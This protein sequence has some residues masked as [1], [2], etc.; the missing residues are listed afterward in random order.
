MPRRLRIAFA[1]PG[2]HRVARGAETAF[3]QIARR[4]ASLGHHVTVFG[5]G[6]PRP[7][8]PYCYRRIPCVPREFFENWPKFPC[9]RTNYAWEELTFSAGLLL[10]YRPGDFDLAIGCSY[11]Y[12]NWILSRGIGDF[13]R[14]VFVTQNGD[15]MIQNRSAEYRFFDCDAVVC[16]NAQ[17]FARHGER[18]PSALIPNGVDPDIFYPGRADRAA[19][20]LP[21]AGPVALMVSA[22]IP[23]KRVVEGV[24]A[25]ANVPGLFLVVAGDGECR[26][27]VDNEAGHLMPGRY[28]RLSLPRER[29]PGL[30]RCADA[31]LH[32]SRDEASANAYMEA[33][34][35]GLPIVTHDW[36]VT[37]WTLEDCAHL[38]NCADE[39]AVSAALS[40]AIEAKSPEAISRR[41]QLVQ[42]RFAWSGIAEQYSKFLQQ[43]CEL[44]PLQ[45][46]V[47]APMPDV[48]V[49]VIGRNEGQRL[50]RCLES[51]SGKAAALVYVDSASGDQSVANAQRIGAQVVELD[52]STPFTAARAR[53]AGVERLKQ[54]APHVKYVQF[55]DGDCEAR[56]SWLGRARKEFDAD[57]KLAA[58]CGRRRE[59]YPRRSIYNR[60]M[61][62]EWDTQ[63]GPAKSV[64][65]D[66]MFRLEAF[67]SAGG[68]DPGV[69]A[70]EEPQ[71]CLRLRH[72]HWK[73]LRADA[74]MTLHDAAITRLG[75]WWRRQVRGGYGALDVYRRFNVD[76]ERLFAKPT[77]SAALWATLW[78]AAVIVAGLIGLAFGGRPAGFAAAGVVFAAL[79]LQIARLSAR[80]FFQGARPRTALAYGTLTM[81]AKW[82]W[83]FGQLQY[84]RQQLRGPRMQPMEYKQLSPRRAEVG[85]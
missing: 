46:Q 38:V 82:A 57:P 53:N 50:V 54:I 30:Y 40:R 25:A 59:R 3:E 71:L 29:M 67:D 41:R 6:P 34:A 42:R 44:S 72:S 16:T 18:Y 9:L 1:L 23:S 75:Q 13:P 62:L 65:G 61:D 31:F 14:H 83:F 74:E 12:V 52:S 35:T 33:L 78:P 79:P 58:V 24:R 21:I 80:T 32:M 69:V 28:L 11:P 5:S 17:Y 27:D 77:R 8:E 22:L 2:L 39:K 4:L 81:L 70:G 10:R 64:G 19:Y 48:G 56:P 43:L 45:G 55:V 20:G 73:V 47:D 60:L 37:R 68:F 76:G 26:R 85:G 15:W 36:E 51:V 7:H 84:R 63:I 66:A 49:V